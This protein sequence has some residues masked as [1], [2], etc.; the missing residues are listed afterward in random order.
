[1]KKKAF[2]I[3][4]AA[5]VLVSGSIGGT[6]AWFTDSASVTNTFTV[7]SIKMTLDETNLSYHEGVQGS[8]PR[9][10]EN[11]EG[12]KIVPGTAIPKDPMVTIAANSEDCYVFV[13]IINGLVLDNAVVGTPNIATAWQPVEEGSNIYVYTGSQPTAKVVSS[14]T[15]AQELEKVFTTITISGTNVTSENINSLN[16]K[17]VTVAAFA[18]QSAA[19]DYSTALSAA[20]AHFA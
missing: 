10:S 11:Q 18:H 14:S 1:M 15:S 16:G 20:K 13:Q 17:T 7:G 5:V 6:L 12:Y 3:I 4:L 2:L 9:T 8:K 19:T